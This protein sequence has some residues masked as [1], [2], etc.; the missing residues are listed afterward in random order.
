MTS[1]RVDIKAVLADP[2]ER[3]RMMVDSLIFIQ[4]SQGR[5]LTEHEAGEVYDRVLASLPVPPLETP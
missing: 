4:A 1:R 2:V 5:V 3:R